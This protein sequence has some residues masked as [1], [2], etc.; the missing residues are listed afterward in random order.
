MVLPLLKAPLLSMNARVESFSIPGEEGSRQSQT[1]TRSTTA[2]SD[3]D[4]LDIQVAQAYRQIFFHAFKGDREAELE[5]QLRAGQIT[6]RDFI[7]GLLL[8]KKFRDGFYR[9][10]SNYRI[11]EQIV[12]RVL[13]RPVHGDRE[14]MAYSILIAQRGLA[15]MVDELME[16]EEYLGLF[17]YDT[18]PYQ[19][20]RVLPGRPLGTMPFNQQAPRYGAYWR[21]TMAKR[22]PAKLD[23]QNGIAQRPA[24][25]A[26][27]PAPWARKLW[28][29]TVA[30]GGFVVTG[31]ILWIAVA[32]LST[33]GN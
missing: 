22:A 32:M 33:G 2:T 24:W 3:R 1:A 27:A 29:N 11:V 14:C 23:W 21:D 19:R 7:R 28:Q 30:A 9:C 4:D 16:S 26:D 20:S 25:L 18:V 13:G 10:N 17:G 15:A 6:M 12:G 5:S 8:S 31:L